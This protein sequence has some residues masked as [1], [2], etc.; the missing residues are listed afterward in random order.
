M[1]PLFAQLRQSVRFGPEQV[2]QDESHGAHSPAASAYLPCGVHEAIHAPSSRYGAAPAQVVHRPSNEQV[3]QSPC[4]ASVVH[5]VQMDALLASPRV[6]ANELSTAQLAEQ[7]SSETRLPSSQSSSVAQRPSPQILAQLS[8][9][10]RDPPVHVN[11]R[12]GWQVD[13]QP[14]PSSEFPSSQASPP[15]EMRLPSPHTAEQLLLRLIPDPHLSAPSSAHPS[16]AQAHPTSIWQSASQPS[17]GSVLLSSH[18]SALE[19][20]PSPQTCTKGT[21]V[22]SEKLVS[23]ASV[24]SSTDGSST[25]S[26][27]ASS[28]G[29]EPL[30]TSITARTTVELCVR[31]RLPTPPEATTSAV[32]EGCAPTW[33]G[34]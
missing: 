8:A 10:E 11:P 17:S 33:A 12:S 4:G 21:S 13:E 25:P 20:L 24:G 15:H 6:H 34:G 1:L 14:S 9:C 22:T 30:E 27:I 2:S 18:C 23:V 5:G 19:R 7:P 28:S 32:I 31:R 26:S 16:A 3:W 29:D